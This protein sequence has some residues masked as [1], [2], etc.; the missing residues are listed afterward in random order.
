MDLIDVFSSLRLM[1]IS[2]SIEFNFSLV[3]RVI[4]AGWKWKIES[5]PAVSLSILRWGRVYSLFWTTPI[6]SLIFWKE[7]LAVIG[8]VQSFVVLA[9]LW[10]SLSEKELSSSIWL[11]KL[12]LSLIV[13]EG[14]AE[15]WDS[16]G[17]KSKIKKEKQ[18]PFPSSDST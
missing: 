9:Y 1:V 5:P 14:E 6:Y 18:L 13:F 4:A 15:L 11:V 17:V 2:G 10:L 8:S 7:C 12:Q 16:N 3:G